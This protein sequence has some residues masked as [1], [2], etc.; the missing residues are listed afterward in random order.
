MLE[1]ELRYGEQPWAT[2]T[3]TD[4]DQRARLVLSSSW[5]TDMVT[6][7]VMQGP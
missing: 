6:D 1:R 5:V 7:M 4:S 3:T 2:T